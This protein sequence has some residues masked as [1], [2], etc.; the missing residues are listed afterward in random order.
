[1]QEKVGIVLASYNGEHY[2]REQLDSILNGTYKNL[3]IHVFDDG[4]SDCTRE[5]VREY[6]RC[7]PGQVVL[8][9]NAENKG[10]IKNFLCG[11]QAAEEAYIMLCDQDDVW[12]P[13]KI[14]KT[15]RAMQKAEGK[16]KEAAVVFTDARVVDAKLKPQGASFYKRSRYK[17]D[18]MGL[19][20]MLMENKLIGCTIMLN[21]KI[22]ERI[23]VIP[24]SARMHDWWIALIGAAFGKIAFLEEETILYR[25]H[26]SN[27]V[28]NQS[29]SS[30]IASRLKKPGQQRKML[31]Q[32]EKQ[33]A[34]FLKIY[35]KELTREQALLVEEFACIRRQGFL[36]RRYT[37][38]KNKY[39]KSGAVRN[40]G[41]LF[42]L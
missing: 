34:E 24:T 29:F 28:G 15:M 31:L 2:I 5:I 13:D 41:V 17:L 7:Y 4:S 32:T 18:Q 21:R 16:E 1:M 42:F 26:G 6:E 36:K 30:Y 23:T 38:I 12:L 20:Y 27:V 10:V 8:N 25:Q 39:L 22:K 37:V 35:K 14:E 9:E 11:I 3:C 33:A 40:L 19:S